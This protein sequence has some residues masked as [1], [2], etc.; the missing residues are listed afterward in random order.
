MQVAV[1]DI[2]KEATHRPLYLSAGGSRVPLDLDKAA[3]A[4]SCGSSAEASSTRAIRLSAAAVASSARPST[5]LRPPG[6]IEATTRRVCSAA[7]RLATAAEE[8]LALPPRSD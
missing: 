5:R 6:R 2:A 7:I 1:L 8:S 3:I 4:H